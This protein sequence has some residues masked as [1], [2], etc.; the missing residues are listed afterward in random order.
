MSSFNHKGDKVCCSCP[1][2][3]N[4][5]LAENYLTKFGAGDKT[6]MVCRTFQK[7]GQCRKGIYCRDRHSEED[8]V[9]NEIDLKKRRKQ[10]ARVSA[11]HFFLYDHRNN[12]DEDIDLEI[13]PKKYTIHPTPRCPL[14]RR[15]WIMTDS[16]EGSN[17]ELYNYHELSEN[18]WA[19][20]PQSESGQVLYYKYVS[21]EPNATLCLHSAEYASNNRIF[22]S[23]GYC[24]VQDEWGGLIS[25]SAG[26][27]HSQGGSN[28]VCPVAE[29]I[30]IL[31][32]DNPEFIDERLCAPLL[33]HLE[34]FHHE[35]EIEGI[36]I[37]A[38]KL[39]FPQIYNISKPNGAAIPH[40][41]KIS[42][43]TAHSLTGTLHSRS[44]FRI[45][46]FAD[47][48][49]A[50]SG[51][52][53]FFSA[54][55]SVMAFLSGI[56]HKRP[57]VFRDVIDSIIEKPEVLRDW[58]LLQKQDCPHR[59]PIYKID[60][61]EA[62]P[63]IEE[64]SFYFQ[65]FLHAFEENPFFAKTH[66][67]QG[68]NIDHFIPNL[69][70]AA[71]I[72]PYAPNRLCNCVHIEYCQLPTLFIGMKGIHTALHYDR[73]YDTIQNSSTTT[74]IALRTNDPGKHNLFLQISGVRKFILFEPEHEKYLMPDI[75]SLTN[76]HVS[77]SLTFIHS[78][79]EYSDHLSQQLRYINNSPY[80]S[81]AKAWPDKKEIILNPGDAL[82][83]PA[84]WWHYTEIVETGVAM[85]WSFMTDC[86]NEEMKNIVK[87]F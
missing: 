56:V 7:T 75:H 17:K 21:E 74:P 67:L 57:T 41:P 70:N 86:L 9:E 20:V 60:H 11:L 59:I 14:M 61:L 49:V 29:V 8:D 19:A 53:Q 24:K 39:H 45:P 40:F 84:R 63:G 47:A 64:E 12:D 76:Y 28:L 2:S 32:S 44:S 69:I 68:L 30:S 85:N 15:Q 72:S 3:P 16:G 5:P 77:R 22:L 66:Y 78:V 18:M 26:Y 62:I 83:I 25:E 48:P 1:F 23:E 35:T 79:L 10:I 36:T 4:C 73:S 33:H 50:K 6:R 31:C 55:D 42:T 81:L 13:Y 27:F 87:N 52:E 65:D 51:G 38:P 43:P 71:G 37:V 80:S 34:N 82:L 54:A 46:I 58:S